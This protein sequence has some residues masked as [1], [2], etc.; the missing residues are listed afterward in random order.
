MNNF[1][2]F[3]KPIFPLFARSPPGFLSLPVENLVLSVVIE[4]TWKIFYY[5]NHYICF[6]NAIFRESDIIYGTS[7]HQGKDVTRLS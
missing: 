5:L 3:P 4:V 7:F 2:D 1:A 6:E